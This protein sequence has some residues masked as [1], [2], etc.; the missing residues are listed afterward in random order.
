MKQNRAQTLA[1]IDQDEGPE[2]NISAG[3]PGGSSCHGVTMQLYQE[4]N[5][6]IGKAP[7]DL[8]DMRMM[9]SELAGVIYSRAFLDPLRFDELPAGVDY[10]IADA[11]ITLGKTGACLIVQMTLGV[12]P[13]N[14]EMDDRTVAQLKII[15]PE[16]TIIALSAAWLAW[17]HGLSADGW[18]KYN[19]GWY[20]RVVNVNARAMGLI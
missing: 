4:Y 3:E 19:H 11:A 10:R 12:Y 20:N 1:W 16:T 17:K 14:G 6:F 18:T 2:L 15:P 8:Q 5:K 9:T 7:P 13:F